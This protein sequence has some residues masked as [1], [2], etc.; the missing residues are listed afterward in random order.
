MYL[1]GLAV[2]QRRPAGRDEHRGGVLPPY[3]RRCEQ[4]LEHRVGSHAIEPRIVGKDWVTEIPALERALNERQPL[5]RFSDV[6][7]MTAH[8]EQQLR[9]RHAG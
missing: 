3:A 9:I 7:Q 1:R 2:E 6:Y 5:D 4:R 8:V